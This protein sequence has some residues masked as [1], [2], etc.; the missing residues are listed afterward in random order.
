LAAT[1]KNADFTFVPSL[2]ALSQN[3]TAST[4]PQMMAYKEA[5]HLHAIAP[6]ETMHLVFMV[7]SALAFILGGTGNGLVSFITSC[8]KKKRVDDMWHMNMAIAGFIFT[9]FL[10][11][12]VVQVALGF[13][14][15]LRSFLCKITNIITSLSMF[16]SSFHLMA[17]SVDHCVTTVWPAW[18][19]NHHT[20]HLASL[21]GLGIWILAVMVSWRYHDLCSDQSL[22]LRESGEAANVTTRFLVGFLIPLALIS[23]FLVTLAAKLGQ[24]REAWSKKPLRTLLILL[25]IFFLC[26]S[27]YH[28]IAFLQTSP[29][30]SSPKT[31][32]SLETGTVFAHGLL[33]FNSCFYPFF[34]LITRQHFVGC[35]RRRRISQTPVNVGS[36]LVELGANR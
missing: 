35:Q 16:S 29:K 23:I 4:Y 15:Y 22:L 5:A 33:C 7:L 27:P 31:T 6:L 17:I 34:Y 18:A 20:F 28:I 13:H 21:I 12:M 36:E 25:V 8:R 32:Q 19:Q 10:P 14:W 24:K 26:W 2:F 11:L 9:V 30:A 1:V 3:C